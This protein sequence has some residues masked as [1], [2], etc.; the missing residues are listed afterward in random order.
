MRRFILY[1]AAAAISVS[2]LATAMTLTTHHM[3]SPLCP[4]CHAADAPASAKFD[5]T[6]L[7]T[8]RACQ[9][10]FYG[11]PRSDFS[12]AQAIEE[13]LDDEPALD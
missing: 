4:R 1:M 6:T 7:Y 2:L 10:A 12:W 9:K 13:W 3:A 11:P 8:C 5:T